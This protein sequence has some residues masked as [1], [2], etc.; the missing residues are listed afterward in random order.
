MVDARFSR[1]EVYVIAFIWTA[2]RTFFLASTVPFTQD[3]F[4]EE[5]NARTEPR[6]EYGGGA[7]AL[8]SSHDAGEG[9]EL[10]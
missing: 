6:P 10:Q 5:A 2:C 1:A 7:A 3:V 4:L 8:S 9:V